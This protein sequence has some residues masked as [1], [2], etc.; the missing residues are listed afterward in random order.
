MEADRLVNSL[1]AKKDLDTEMTVVRNEWEAGENSPMAVL[2]KRIMAAA[3]EWH[4]Y[5]HTTIG[6]RSDLEN[7]PIEKL[8]AFYRKHYQPDN[9]VLMVAG[10]L[11]ETRTLQLIADSFGKIPAPTRTLEVSYT[12]EPAQDGE[13]LVTLR[14]V[15]DVQA[16]LAA[17]HIP[18]GSHRTPRR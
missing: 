11:D 17:Y 14:R 10:K 1:V 4:N 9:A 12:E 13:R 15:G 2:Q 5:G 6:A 16:A 8:Q 3:Y 18:A 7:V